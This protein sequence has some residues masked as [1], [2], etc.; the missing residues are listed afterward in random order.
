VKLASLLSNHFHDIPHELIIDFFLNSVPEDLAHTP[1]YL[2]ITLLDETDKLS[3]LLHVTDLW[4][5]H[6]LDILVRQFGSSD[7]KEAMEAHRSQVATFYSSSTI[8]ECRTEEWE[9]REWNQDDIKTIELRLASSWDRQRTLQD[10]NEFG[11]E[12]QRRAGYEKHEM[13]LQSVADV[14][15]FILVTDGADLARLQN[16]NSEFFRTN[17]I[18]EVRAAGRSIYHVESI[19]VRAIVVHCLF[20]YVSL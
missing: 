19:K 12:L 14:A 3:E 18:L 7:C 17:N 15:T 6:L 4:H 11:L 5:T 2:H 13:R 1:E 10:L 8:E 16:I 9:V 20:H